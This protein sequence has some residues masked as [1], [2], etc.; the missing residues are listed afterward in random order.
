MYTDKHPYQMI[1][2]I[3]TGQTKILDFLFW[4]IVQ[5]DERIVYVHTSMNEKRVY[6]ETNF[7]QTSWKFSISASSFP[8]FWC[9]TFFFLR[10]IQ[11]FFYIVYSVIN[12]MCKNKTQWNTTNI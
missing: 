12:D 5:K 6:K 7:S 1:S 9:Q 8:N 2:K 3:K 11:A 4:F 10:H